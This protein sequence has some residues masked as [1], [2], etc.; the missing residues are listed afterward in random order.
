MLKT[1]GA[2]IGIVGG[3][4]SMLGAAWIA[5]MNW[6]VGGG[7]SNFWWMAVL[8]GLV[9]VVVC[10]LLIK[11]YLFRTAVFA[12]YDY[13]LYIVIPFAVGFYGHSI[14]EVFVRSY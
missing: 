8:V 12:W 7:V 14:L 9:A 3:V 13:I 10:F 4:A 2:F 11:R 6:P 1:I 5:F